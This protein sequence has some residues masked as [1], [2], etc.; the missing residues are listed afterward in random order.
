ME[1]HTENSMQSHMETVLHKEIGWYGDL[2]GI[3]PLT[4]E[5][6]R[7]K[8]REHG[9]QAKGLGGHTLRMMDYHMDK[10]MELAVGTE[11]K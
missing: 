11:V 4:G 8:K 6:Q 2:R 3:A 1:N 10:N 9:V 7:E 5:N